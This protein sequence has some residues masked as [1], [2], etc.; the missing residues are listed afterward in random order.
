MTRPQILA[1]A[2]DLDGL[3]FNTEALFFQVAGQML[4]ARGK[5]FTREMMAAMI[6]RQAVVAYPAMKR[7][8][9]LPETPEELMAEARKR[10]F[11]EIDT[12]VQ[13]TSGLFVLLQTLQERNIPRAV[14]TS[15]RKEYA[16]R[17]LTNHGLI[18][19]FSY[20]LT[21]EDVTL[22]KPNPEI[23]TK[24]AERFGILPANLLVLEDS[25]AGVSAGK[26]AGAYT[27]GVP[28]DHSPAGP[29]AAADLII[30]RLDATELLGF[31]HG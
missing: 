20:L 3:M 17:L 9:D 24:A 8:A 30:D 5:V 29:L 6:G 15:S 11:A 27:V 21:A 22:G 10:F 4:A 2:F 23:Y 14:C 7:L 25:P 1:V 31:W 19:H 12:A 26:A 18:H 16:T 28:H 13:P